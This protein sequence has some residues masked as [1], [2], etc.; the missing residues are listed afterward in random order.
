MERILI[1]HLANMLERLK[2]RLDVC[3]IVAVIASAIALAAILIA[4][5]GCSPRIV[6][7][8]VTQ[9]EYRDREIH[10]TTTIEI[11]KEVEKIVTRDTVSH[12][13]NTYGKSDAVVS[14]GFLH[15]SLETKPQIIK[16]PFTVTVTDTLWKESE[17]HEVIKEVEKPLSWWRKFEIGAVWALLGALV[18]AAFFVIKKLIP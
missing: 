17:I 10:D 8:I 13:E 16:V 1:R 9:I 15:H 5:T 14:G 11:P 4:L 7:K 3:H 12:L 6:E 2:K 18:T